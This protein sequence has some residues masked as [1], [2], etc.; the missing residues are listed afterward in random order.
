MTTEEARAKCHLFET[1]RDEGKTDNEIWTTIFEG[2]SN[3]EI[4]QV[5]DMAMQMLKEEVAQALAEGNDRRLLWA[6]FSE[7]I[8]AE[9][10]NE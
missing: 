6:I 8:V 4:M 1:L 2:L 3:D 5:C 7:F 9:K 10:T